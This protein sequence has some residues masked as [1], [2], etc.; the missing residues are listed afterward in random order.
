MSEENIN[1]TEEPVIEETPEAVVASVYLYQTGGHFAPAK[2]NAR[3]GTA[4]KPVRF[5]PLADDGETKMP[6]MRRILSAEQYA[7]WTAEE[8]ADKRAAILAAIEPSEQ[9]SALN[10]TA[11]QLASITAMYGDRESFA[12]ALAAGYLAVPHTSHAKGAAT[13]AKS[14]AEKET[15]KRDAALDL[16][17]PAIA[18]STEETPTEETPDVPASEE[19]APDA[20]EA[21]VVATGKRQK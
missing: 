11:E 2:V 4:V 16:M 21:P 5:A 17:F 18:E 13:A 12:A 8:D 15:E 3:K 19:S 14:R 6:V 9:A 7:E 1:T 10:P 20:E